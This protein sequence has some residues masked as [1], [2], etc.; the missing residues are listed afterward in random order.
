MVIDIMREIGDFKVIPYLSKAHHPNW[1]HWWARYLSSNDP[2]MHMG[3]GGGVA[4]A[5]IASLTKPD[6][7][8]EDALSV[9]SFALFA[10]DH[11]SSKDERHLLAK[12]FI[13]EVLR[14][15]KVHDHV[16]P[17]AVFEGDTLSSWGSW[18]AAHAQT[19]LGL[20]PVPAGP[21]PLPNPEL[22]VEEARS[23]IQELVRALNAADFFEDDPP[24]HQ[25]RVQA[26]RD[27]FLKTPI[28]ARAELEL[29]RDGI[30]NLPLFSIGEEADRMSGLALSR[31]QS[32]MMVRDDDGGFRLAARSHSRASRIQYQERYML[33]AEH[34]GQEFEDITGG[35]P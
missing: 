12:K 35:T 22:N 6:G 9:R 29:N 10:W 23:H 17:D 19:A 27:S 21:G 11:F 34:L 33:D 3:K 15:L 28:G 4:E 8:M 5:K 26:A 32:A 30:T 16:R 14:A 31:V 13:H 2:L 1:E 24:E 20:A 7:S 25:C 18:R